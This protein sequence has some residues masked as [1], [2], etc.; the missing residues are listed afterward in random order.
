MFM[1]SDQLARA[2]RN[3]KRDERH[4]NR[5]ERDTE[6]REAIERAGREYDE[7]CERHGHPE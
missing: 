7:F 1:T 6:Y 5:M 4:K 3:S 2:A